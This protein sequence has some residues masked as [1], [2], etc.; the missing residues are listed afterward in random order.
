M[1]PPPPNMVPQGMYPVTMGGQQRPGPYPPQGGP[2]PPQPAPPQQSAYPPQ[3]PPMASQSQ[4]PP[5]PSRVTPE[6]MPLS[7]VDTLSD[8][9]VEEMLADD[10]KLTE[11]V[12][13]LPYVQDYMLREDAVKRLQDEVNSLSARTTGNP[14]I[15]ARRAELDQKRREFQEKAQMRQAKEGEMTQGALFEKLDAAA[16]A[17]DA[18]CEEI[19]SRFLSGEIDAKEFAKQYKEKRFQFHIRSAKKE[20][21]LHNM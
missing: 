13:R 7:Q 5:P 14:E 20:S 18:E 17:T 4:A 16:R 9:Q 12:R 10:A 3:V 1:A 15:D 2:Q 6:S 11:F 19:A 8:Q 21:M